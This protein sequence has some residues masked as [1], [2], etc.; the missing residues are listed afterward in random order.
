MH[1]YTNCTGCKKELKVKS[2]APTRP[3]LIMDKGEQFKMNC[4][5]CGKLLN[6]SVNDVKA[7]MNQSFIIVGVILGVLLVPILWIYIAGVSTLCLS[8]PIWIW[9]SEQDATKLFNS[10]RI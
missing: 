5:D 2:F 8:I 1:L 3:E 4:N 6:V 7:K 10:Y 9:K